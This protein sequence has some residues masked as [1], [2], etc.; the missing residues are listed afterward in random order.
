VSTPQNP[1]QS[2]LPSL[3][4]IHG[5]DHDSRDAIATL[6]KSLGI[7]V[8]TWAEALT[9]LPFNKHDVWSVVKQGFSLAHGAIVILSPDEIS[10]LQS[11]F[12]NPKD[13]L[14]DRGPRFQPRPNV[15]IELGYALH[16]WEDRTM[17]IVIGPTKLPS[18]RDG[19]WTLTI[20]GGDPEKEPSAFRDQFSVMIGSLFLS[21]VNKGILNFD[22]EQFLHRIKSDREHWWTAGDIESLSVRESKRLVP[23]FI[24]AGVEVK[25]TR[26]RY[27]D[28]FSTG[29]EFILTGTNFGDQMGDLG[30]PPG[31]LHTLI[32]DK[33]KEN[34]HATVYVVLAPYE[35][36][37]QMVPNSIADLKGRS[38]GRLKLLQYDPRLT[39][40]ERRRLHIF[41][42]RGA[43]FLSIALRL[44]GGPDNGKGLVV[45]TPRWFKDEAGPQR[46]FFAIEQ[47]IN[48]EVFKAFIA[49]IYPSIK[50]DE[51]SL[52]TRKDSTLGGR[53]IDEICSALGVE[54][55]PYLVSMQAQFPQPT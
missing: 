45:V 17:Q 33:I 16:E 28:F 40:D 54:D 49:P 53:T 8:I 35:L 52:R 47:N 6:V 18:D 23:S 55:D 20:S 43:T 51:V 12:R 19:K 38:A 41:D 22:V 50:V 48:P 15:L 13:G 36:L 1:I 24:E 11:E 21:L 5:R 32:I 7:E 46:M 10:W 39:E 31:L 14:V 37:E 2:K 44:S 42:H 4:L 30:T 27:R 26:F 34:K 29:E 3:F 9:S 25:Q